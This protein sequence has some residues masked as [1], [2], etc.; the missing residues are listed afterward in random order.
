M[1]M[2][3]VRDLPDHTKEKLRVHAALS[4]LS[5]EAYVRHLLQMAAEADNVAPVD[6][7]ALAQ[8][9]FGKQGIDLELPSRTSHRGSVDFKP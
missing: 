9:H 2:I 8:K 1:A 5:L 7:V 4:G 6:I 3:T